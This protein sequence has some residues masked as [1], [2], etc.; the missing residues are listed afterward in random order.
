MLAPNQQLTFSAQKSITDYT[1]TKNTA[2][3]PEDKESTWFVHCWEYT[4]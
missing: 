3:N 4:N 1:L 2:I